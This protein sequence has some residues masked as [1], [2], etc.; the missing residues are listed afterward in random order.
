MVFFQNEDDRR[1]FVESGLVRSEM[2]DR[3]PGSGVDLVRFSFTPFKP[4]SR[5]RMRFLLVARML[6][7]KGVGEYVEAARLVRQRHPHAEFCLLGFLDVKNPTAISRSQMDEW[8]AEGVVT[9]LGAADDVRPHIVEGDCMVLPSYREGVPRTL[10]EAAA[11]GRPIITTDAVGC[12]EVVDDR[13]NGFLCKPRDVGDLA[14]KL[15]QMIRLSPAD[16]SEMGRRG[17][18]KMEREFDEKIVI[19]KYLKVVGELS[20][21]GN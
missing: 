6:W 16:R 1:F 11:M 3:L 17:R 7:E 10:L 8:I 20:Q 21:Q 15:E 2:A 9:Y 18:E 4:S 19:S 14:A 12:R 13:I 5:K